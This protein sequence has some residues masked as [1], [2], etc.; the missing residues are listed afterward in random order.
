MGRIIVIGGGARSGKS[1]FAL[2]QA[3]HLGSE[4]VFIAT[5]V[6]FDEE[7]R[8]RIERH[9]AERDARFRIREEPRNLVDALQADDSH[10]VVLVDCLTL[11]LSNLLVDGQSVAQIEA[12]VDRLTEALRES[13]PHVIVVTNEVGLGVVPEHRLGRLFRD[14]AGRTH[15][16]LAAMADEVYFGAMG[17][18]LQLKPGPVTTVALGEQREST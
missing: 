12:T 1:R 10:D 9:K 16:R 7:M 3:A 4:P 13:E 18:M 15:Q 8:A 14:I 5:A 11:W 17:C 6:A 2:Q